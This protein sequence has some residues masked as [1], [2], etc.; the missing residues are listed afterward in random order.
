MVTEHGFLSKSSRDTF[1]KNTFIADSGAA[2]HM[3]GSLEGLFDLKLYFTDIM[4]GNNDTNL[5]LL[6]PLTFILIKF[7]SMSQDVYL[8]MK[9]IPLQITLLPMLR[10]WNSML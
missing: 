10:H 2:Y 9:S 7:T 3:F 4:M 1:T 5:Y 6:D 8:G